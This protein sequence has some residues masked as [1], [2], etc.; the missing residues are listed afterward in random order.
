MT[1]PLIGSDHLD[2]PRMNFFLLS[3][4][5]AGYLTEKGSRVRTQTKP[6]KLMT[7]GGYESKPCDPNGT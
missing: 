2:G 6:S 5:G 7:L 3:A 1:D 4:S